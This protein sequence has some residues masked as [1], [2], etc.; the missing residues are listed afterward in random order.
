[1]RCCRSLPGQARFSDAESSKIVRLDNLRYDSN[2]S[3]HLS[4]QCPCRATIFYLSKMAAGDICVHCIASCL[5]VTCFVEYLLPRDAHPGQRLKHVLDEYQLDYH[6]VLGTPYRS[7][8]SY[9]Q[10]LIISRQ[11]FQGVAPTI[12]GGISDRIGRRPAYFLSFTLFI[13]ANVGLALQTNFVAL[14]ILSCVQS[15]GSSGTTALS[16]AVVSDVAT[17]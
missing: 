5:C 16:S 15:C 2:Q 6:N 10:R 3:S 1:M 7:L 8:I 12:V 11:I 17:R 14:L 9:S 13:A 4:I